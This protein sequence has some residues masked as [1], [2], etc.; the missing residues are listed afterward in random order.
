M[1]KNNFIYLLLFCL[2]ITL[3]GCSNFKHQHDFTEQIIEDSY[4]FSEATCTKKAKYYY[5]CKTC[6]EKG[7]ETFEYGEA[8][9]HTEVIDKKVEATTTLDGLTEGKH[10]S[11]CNEILVE[12]KIIYA[13]GSNGLIIDGDTV[14]GIGTCTDEHI[15][16]PKHS[17]TGT[18]ITKIDKE[19]FSNSSII[20]ITIPN[21]ITLIDTD[22]FINCNELKNIYITDLSAW[23]NIVGIFNLTSYNSNEKFLYL[24]DELITNLIIPNDISQING[25]TFSNFKHIKSITFNDNIHSILPLAFK[26]C[27]GITSIEIPENIF[28]ID[29]SA[30]E[31]CTGLNNIVIPNSVTFLGHSV[32]KGCTNL[33]T[34][35][36]G[37]GITY[38][39]A[40]LFEGCINLKNVTT[41]DNIETISYGA[42]MGCESLSDFVISKKV[43]AIGSYAFQNCYSITSLTIPNS[44]TSISSKAFFGCTNLVN[45]I[46]SNKLNNIGEDAFYNCEKLKYNEYDNAYYLGSEDNPYLVLV[47]AK[48]DTIISCLIHVKTK[49]IA[50]S[51]FKGCSKLTSIEITD[52]VTTIGTLAFSD[53]ANLIDV[54]IAKNVSVIEFK[55]FYNSSNIQN[56]YYNGS[57]HD[58]SNIKIETGNE[59]L[60]TAHRFY[61]V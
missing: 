24:N 9:G 7:T 59:I 36:L 56:V 43:T 23:C 29:F 45:L 21:T 33:N 52:N 13:T 25:A 60:E 18:E 35:T 34:A 41:S 8:N 30:F 26:G 48:E 27:N 38:I 11:V 39:P 54:I 17:T 2:I 32:F 46:L 19:A 15:I 16:I 44:V 31:D 50:P 1:K 61:L 4:L 53:C 10:C 20:S 37:T 55:A 58:W 12:Q 40:N 57:S 51:S 6:K 14:K 5:A 28:Y 3:S 47:K 42:F 22:A 49:I